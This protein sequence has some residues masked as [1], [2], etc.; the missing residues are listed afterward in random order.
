MYLVF[1]EEG[2]K[3]L[4]LVLT[5]L[6][7]VKPVVTTNPTPAAPQ[8]NDYRCWHCS[9]PFNDPKEFLNHITECR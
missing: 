8:Q 1:M 3:H 5:I 4:K 6:G 7:A 9:S 2:S